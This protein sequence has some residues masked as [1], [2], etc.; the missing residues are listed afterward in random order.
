M[1]EVNFRRINFEVMSDTK[2]QYESNQLIRAMVRQSV[3]KQYMVSHEEAIE[4]QPIT[5]E[6]DN[7]IAITSARALAVG[8]LYTSMGMKVAI[9]NFANNHSIG[10]APFSAGAQEESICRCTTLLPCLEAMNDVF[11]EKHRQQY[12]QGKIDYMG[13]DDLI[14]TPQVFVFKKEIRRKDGV[15]VPTMMERKDWFNVDIITCAAPELWHGNPMPENYEEQLTSR[16][17]KIMSVAQKE[18]VDV[19]VL[20]AWGCGAF[21]N[22]SVIVARVMHAC[23]A[24]Y[25]FDTVTFAMGGD[26]AN[27]A[28]AKEF[29]CSDTEDEQKIVNLLKSTKRENID[30]LIKWMRENNFFS[31]PASVVHHNN[32]KGGLAKH[33]LEVFYEALKLNK[34]AKLPMNSII[35]CSLLHDICKADQYGFDEFCRPVSYKEKLAKGHGR[36]SMFIVNRR[37]R[38][39]LNYYEEMAIW[40]HMGDHEPN[41]QEHQAQFFE[42]N[43]LELCLLIRQADSNAASVASKKALEMYL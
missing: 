19:L 37:C 32:F 30:E 9:L 34:E 43:H 33:S 25:N 15:I 26:Y 29:S 42:S 41:I 2:K 27:T 11:Y 31:A 3:G 40:W 23:L 7:M 39:P 4:L 1:S 35:L 28:F 8:E 24:K 21:K 20:G 16:V 13:N 36:R 10:G 17:N 22:P 38:I 12:M 6:K 5:E 18:N 14:Y